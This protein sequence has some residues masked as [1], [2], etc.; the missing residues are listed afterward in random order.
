[1]VTFQDSRWLLY[2]KEFLIVQ[3]SIDDQFYTHTKYFLIPNFDKEME[4]EIN[5][6]IL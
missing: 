5:W 3:T 1:M 2:E 6:F 4:P